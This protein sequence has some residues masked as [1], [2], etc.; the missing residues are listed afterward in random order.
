M[1][2]AGLD[3]AHGLLRWGN[4]DRTLLLPSTVFEADETG[5]SYRLRPCVDSIWLKEISLRSGVLT[6]FLVPDGPGLAAA[7]RGT[8]AIPVEESRQSTN[9]WGLRGP[10]PDLQAPLAELFSVIRSC[11][12]FSSAITTRPPS[13]SSAILKTG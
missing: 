11:R 13:V 5:R 7:I 6:F 4:Y 10:E 3:P 2:Y 9:S 12:A 8:V 1:R